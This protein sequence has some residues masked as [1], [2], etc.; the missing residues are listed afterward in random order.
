[1][2][3][4]SWTLLAE[5]VSRSPFRLVLVVAAFGAGDGRKR[6]V[7]AGLI[8]TSSRIDLRSRL[9]LLI[10]LSHTSRFVFFQGP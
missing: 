5:L 8:W 7:V 3:W 10:K 6:V 9:P 2:I 1:M 4:W